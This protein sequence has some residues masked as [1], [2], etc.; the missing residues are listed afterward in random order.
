MGADPRLV[1]YGN[2]VMLAGIGTE[3]QRHGLFDLITLE[4]GRPDALARICA[5]DPRAV[6]FDLAAAQ[7]DFTLALLRDRPELIL[8]GVD[9]SSDKVLVLSGRRE[10]PASVA[11]L[12]R[13]LGV[14][15]TGPDMPPAAEA[16]PS[17]SDLLP[18]G[19]KRG[20]EEREAD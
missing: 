7:P 12:L 9:S 3:L 2:S 18:A 20:R 1:L 16:I 6:L 19:R 14:G 11:D 10:R 17:D 4:P 13:V 5:L 8:I 15:G